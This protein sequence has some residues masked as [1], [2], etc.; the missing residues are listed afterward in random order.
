MK[1]IITNPEIE[2]NKLKQKSVLG[3]IYYCAADSSKILK[4]KG[5]LV[6]AFA[7]DYK[8]LNRQSKEEQTRTQTESILTTNDSVWK[9]P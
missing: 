8:E 7:L 6:G 4:D 9:H 1:W 3:I 2:I 5:V